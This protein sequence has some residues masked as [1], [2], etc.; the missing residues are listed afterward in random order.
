MIGGVMPWSLFLIPTA[1]LV[2]RLFTTSTE[3]RD[4]FAFLLFWIVATY[5]YVQPAHSKL[6]SYIFPVFPA[7]AILI[8]YSLERILEGDVEKFFNKMA[9]SIG[10]LMAAVFAGMGIAAIVMAKKY[11]SYVPDMLPVYV[12]AGAALLWAGAL[13]LASAKKRYGT[14]LAIN[15]SFTCLI[16]L[17]M[18]SS[19]PSIEPWVSCKDISL[20]LNK[21][22]Q[23]PTTLLTSKFYV[24][25]VRFYTDRK[26][27]VININGKG[28]FSPHPIPFLNT[29]EK[30]LSFLEQQPVTYG[31][32]RKNDLGD[33]YRITADGYHLQEL[34]DIGGKHLIKIEKK[35]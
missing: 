22:D 3:N 23:S 17:V 35:S 31:I 30:V 1:G 34:D 13:A 15:A 11:S 8:A 18:F 21:T 33:L 10:Y 32:V 2:Y 26:V 9:E 24:R 16:L 12:F 4:R 20:V 5:L 29:D 28:F 19:R 25:G 27:A 7:I 6:A 14:Q